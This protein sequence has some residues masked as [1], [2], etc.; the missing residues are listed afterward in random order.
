MSE[1][2]GATLR[3]LA[4]MEAL[5]SIPVDD[6][7]G[8]GVFAKKG[9]VTFKGK[10]RE[11]IRGFLVDDEEVGIIEPTE[12]AKIEVRY[13]HRKAE[14]NSIWF[15]AHNDDIAVCNIVATPIH[16]HSSIVQGGPAYGTY[17]SD[18]EVDDG[19]DA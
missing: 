16:D 4:G 7:T 5:I 19:G 13:K 12:N 11:L 2:T 9:P 18:D 3:L 1:F 17:F 15:F 8:L 14:K 10:K 6:T